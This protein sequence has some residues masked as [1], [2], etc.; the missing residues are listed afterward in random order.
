MTGFRVCQRVCHNAE[1]SG[2]VRG[3]FNQASE[4]H[5]KGALFL[6]CLCGGWAAIR[7]LPFF[8]FVCYDNL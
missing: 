2:E 3:A 4:E 7:T 6:S 8:C 5:A 1:I